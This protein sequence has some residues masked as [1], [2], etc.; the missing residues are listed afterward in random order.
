MVFST[1]LKTLVSMQLFTAFELAIDQCHTIQDGGHFH[2]NEAQDFFNILFHTVHGMSVLENEQK[3]IPPS[4][5]PP[6][7]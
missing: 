5:P 6:P 1:K 4:T 3:N 2:G 7:P